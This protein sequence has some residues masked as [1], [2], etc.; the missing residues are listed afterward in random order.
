LFKLLS[1]L[2]FFVGVRKN[3]GPSI[4]SYGM[5]QPRNEKTESKDKKKKG[6]G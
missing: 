6:G 5:A 3:E 2:E 4:V 1:H